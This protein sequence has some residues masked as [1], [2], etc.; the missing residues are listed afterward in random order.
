MVRV[1][2]RSV[3]EPAWVQRFSHF[4][5]G[6][7]GLLPDG[8]LKILSPGKADEGL[9]T[10]TARNPLGSSSLTSRLQIT[11]HKGQSCLEGNSMGVDGSVCPESSNGSQ[12]LELCH[13]QD[14]PLRWRVAP[15]SSCSSTCGGGFQ[16]R[17]VSCVRGPED[18]AGEVDSRR[19]S[20]VGRRPPDTRPCNLLPCALWASTPWG[21]CNGHCAGP[22]WATQHRHVYC[23]DRNATK[24]PQRMCSGLKRPSSLRN[25]STDACALQWRVGPWT[26]CTATCGRHGFQS[27]QVTCTHRRTG[28]PSREHHCTWR[29]RPPSW[30]RCNIL[31]C[32]RAGEC[33]DSTRYCEKV[34]Q[35]EL[36]PLPQFKNRC[37]QSCRNT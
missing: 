4:C 3:K 23:Q 7:V 17:S 18:G 19:C 24:V 31:S 16:I 36:C 30:Q 11:G 14:C 26:Q 2:E 28:K 37:C 35:L 25:C 21:P 1:A 32:G 9:Y 22:G 6:R 29:P 12:A 13:G 33:R 27:R 20:G 15:W 10:C 34:Q 5:A 8:S